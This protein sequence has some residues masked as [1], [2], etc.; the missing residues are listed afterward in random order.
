MGGGGGFIFPT[1][2]L[3]GKMGEKKKRKD[4]ITN[5]TCYLTCCGALKIRETAAALEKR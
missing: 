5:F 2:P 3:G 1:F 4:G